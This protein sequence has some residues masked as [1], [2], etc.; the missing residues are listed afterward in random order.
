MHQGA[1][2]GMH[3]S[4]KS[5]FAFLWSSSKGAKPKYRLYAANRI[6]NHE[7]IRLPK[8]DRVGLKVLKNGKDIVILPAD[9]EYDHQHPI[10]PCGYSLI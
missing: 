3:A 7:R 2:F 6:R 4:I 9:E 10:Y 5:V 1:T 8:P